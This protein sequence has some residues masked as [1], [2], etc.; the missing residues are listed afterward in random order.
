[1]RRVSRRFRTRSQAVAR[2]V[3]RALRHTRPVRDLFAAGSFGQAL[4][5]S[6]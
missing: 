3:R 1:M 5:I 2:F 4:P 6:A